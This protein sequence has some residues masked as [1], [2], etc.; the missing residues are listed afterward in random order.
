MDASEAAKFKELARI[1]SSKSAR[2]I[3]A[4][5]A[6]RAEY[7]PCVEQLVK[8][9]A[10]TLMHERDALYVGFRYLAIVHGLHSAH[11]M[12]FRCVANGLSGDVAALASN[13]M[14]R[15]LQAYD[16][17]PFYLQKIYFQTGERP[18]VGYFLAEALAA[19]GDIGGLERFALAV[20]HRA[21][22][23]GGMQDRELQRWTTLLVDLG[24][25]DLAPRFCFPISDPAQRDFLQQRI[26]TF[27]S[28]SR[29]TIPAR[30]INL[31]SEDRKWRI[32][33]G[34]L[35]RANYADVR[36]HSAVPGITLP[37]GVRRLLAPSENAR[38]LLG[39]GALA[40]WLSHW[41]VWEDVAR[42]SEAFTL[43][44]EDDAVPFTGAGYLESQLSKLKDYPLVWVNERMS[45]TYHSKTPRWD[46]TLVDTWTQL[47]F[48]PNSR[49]GWG[50][51][52]YLLSPHGAEA[53]L[54][55]AFKL[56][57][58]NHV[59]GQMGAVSTT[60]STS[61]VTRIQRE[62]LRFQRDHNVS[63]TILSA[64]F[65]VPA[66]KVRP[67]GLSSTATIHRDM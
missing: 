26:A 6:L 57:I 58:Q 37:R 47:E 2:E 56:G 45:G 12:L 5:P 24:L 41:S 28:S 16:L 43:V 52:G 46:E 33:S 67:F 11:E 63:N 17:S 53:L 20:L 22:V 54:D 61:P 44:L 51:D 32:S 31:D 8:S 50:A 55:M 4:D 23:L 29:S 1:I 21:E 10:S 30:V 39:P 18:Y 19:A 27:N 65:T 38:N 64:C 59:D 66:I 62:I 14:C 25:V 40:C 7:D 15:R 36:R 35:D 3:E 60:C 13:Q 48:W 49:Q 34:A 42:S 9:D